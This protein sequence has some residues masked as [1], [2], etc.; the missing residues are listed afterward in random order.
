MF[1]EQLPHSNLT[2]THLDNHRYA[3]SQ[4]ADNLTSHLNHLSTPGPS[5]TVN[6]NNY[7]SVNTVPNLNRFYQPG[8]SRNIQRSTRPPVPLFPGT[9]ASAPA[10]FD[11]T[12]ANENDLVSGGFSRD[13]QLNMNFNDFMVSDGGFTAVNDA[14]PNANT[15]SP[16]Q[17]FLDHANSAPN[18]NTFT[19]LTTPSMG[20]YSP[21]ELDSFETSPMFDAEEL[22]GGNWSS[23]FHDG[24]NYTP[25]ADNTS[26]AHESVSMSRIA[27]TSSTDFQT[28]VTPGHRM[29]LTS[30]V[31]KNRRTGKLLGS[32]EVDVADSKAFKRAK[33]TMAARKSRQKKRDIEDSLRVEVAAL[34]AERDRWMHLAIAHGAPIPDSPTAISPR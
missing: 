13:E 17:L 27:S 19:N 8:H 4:S 3:T 9:S 18:S 6:H 15:V 33:N 25:A 32:I 20:D 28:P 34:T 30:G 7:S 14:A 23:L 11:A 2:S 26:M 12:M 10:S 31:A 24:D 29:S 16:E 22:N 21:D 1:D 5:A